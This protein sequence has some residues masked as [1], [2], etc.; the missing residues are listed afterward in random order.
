[1]R[2][3]WGVLAAELILVFF[4]CFVCAGFESLAVG[5][6][7]VSWQDEN[8]QAGAAVSANVSAE[9]ARYDFSGI[10][11]YLSRHRLN[12]DG[13]IIFGSCGNDAVGPVGGCRGAGPPH[14]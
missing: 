9:L 14:R 1:M 10:D 7:G 4:L 2:R 3:L 12:Q 11:Q 6:G 5:D 13:G 8:A